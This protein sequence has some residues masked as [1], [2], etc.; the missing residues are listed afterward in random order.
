MGMPLL[1]TTVGEDIVM[2]NTDK[3]YN[4]GCFFIVF[5]VILIIV[6]LWKVIDNDVRCHHRDYNCCDYNTAIIL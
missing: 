3:G 1:R 4:D 5:G 2:S 6:L